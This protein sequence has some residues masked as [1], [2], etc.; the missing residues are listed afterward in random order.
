[1]EGRI[2][3]D[4]VVLARQ[5]GGDVV[6]VIVQRDLAGQRRQVAPRQVQ[7]ACLCFVQIQ[8]GDLGAA[9]E[10]LGGQVA[11]AGAEIGTV[12]AEVVRQL[13]GEQDRCRVGAVPGENAG[14]AEE[15]ATQ[16]AA[17]PSSFAQ[18][19]AKPLSWPP[20]CGAGPV[21]AQWFLVRLPASPASCFRSAS[22][23]RAP[24]LFDWQATMTRPAP[25]A[26]R[27]ARAA[28]ASSRW[29]GGM[30]QHQRVAAGRRRYR[31]LSVD[32]MPGALQCLGE[33]PEALHAVQLHARR[34][35]AQGP[36]LAGT[37]E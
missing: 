33:G 29:R 6:P 18:R 12:A 34:V 24:S 31:Q 22:P 36:T 11:E 5:S 4:E 14:P 7:G 26:P 23:R 1:M 9:R 10:Y 20:A 25:A 21:H 15:A 30:H 2:A 35:F 13:L 19:V 27:P 3:D 16:H 17:G 37:Q 28:R 32:R 8:R